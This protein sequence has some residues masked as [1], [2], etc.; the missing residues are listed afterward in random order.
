LPYQ[1][2]PAAPPPNRA[3]SNAGPSGR[4][5][6]QR[7]PSLAKIIYGFSEIAPKLKHEA[8]AQRSH[9]AKSPSNGRNTSDPARRVEQVILEFDTLLAEKRAEVHALADQKDKMQCHAS[10]FF[11]TGAEDYALCGRLSKKIGK[12]QKEIDSMTV[13]DPHR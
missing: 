8:P 7:A 10:W 4:S 6:R 11:N 3:T 9:D 2:S 13:H 12:I 1:L 5:A